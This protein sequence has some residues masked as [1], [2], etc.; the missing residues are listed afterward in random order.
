MLEQRA[1][2]ARRGDDPGRPGR[3]AR[4]TASST[5]AT[6]TRTR[7]RSSSTRSPRP[8]APALLGPNILGSGRAF[9]LEIVRQ[10]GRLHLRRGERR[11]W[12]RSRASAPSRAT[13]RRSPVT[14]GLYGKPT[15]INNVETFVLRAG[16]SWR[17]G[18]DWFKAQGKN[19]AAGLKFVGVS[20]DV[21]RPGVFEI[22]DGHAGARGDLRPGRRR[23]RRPHAQGVRA[24]GPV[25]A[26][27]CRPR[28]ST[29][30]LDFN[31]AGRGGLHARL[32]R[33]V[34]VCDDRACML[35]M[36]LN[37]VRFFRNESCGKCV[38]CRVGSAK[39]VEMLGRDRAR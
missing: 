7:S 36:A 1:A 30:P 17:T 13:S 32:R 20:G 34:V 22:A 24:V 19:G 5:S 28:C 6:S 31:V 10:P 3:P 37:A 15:V 38:P 26:A 18:A 8:R 25:V 23:R 14:H 2:P 16:R 4:G 29:L 9:E 11:C 33:A 27:S 21:A 12:R 35:D 39:L